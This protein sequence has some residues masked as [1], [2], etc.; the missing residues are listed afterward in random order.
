M[1]PTSAGG[2]IEEREPVHGY[3]QLETETDAFGVAA[4]SRQPSDEGPG[5]RSGTQ[6]A[7][8]ASADG[9]TGADH[10]RDREGE[11]LLHAARE[12]E[13]EPP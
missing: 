8:G 7:I 13:L 1:T 3:C 12:V 11:A 2:R 9:M 4:A 6:V 10:R 5:L